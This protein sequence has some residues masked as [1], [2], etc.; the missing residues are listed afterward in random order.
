MRVLQ[1]LGGN[2]TCSL[3]DSNSLAWRPAAMPSAFG[4]A[5]AR[6]PRSQP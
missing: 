1:G 4:H 6:T 2:K 3:A 5:L